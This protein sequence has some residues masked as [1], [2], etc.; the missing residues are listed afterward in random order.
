MSRSAGT[1]RCCGSAGIPRR[2][3]ACHAQ[4]CGW[5]VA[6][7]KMNPASESR[8]LTGRDGQAAFECGSIKVS[9]MSLTIRRKRGQSVR[10]G[11]AVLT[12]EASGFGGARLRID[13][14]DHVRIVR[15]DGPE[16]GASASSADPSAGP[17]VGMTLRRCRRSH[18][19][20]LEALRRMFEVPPLQA[21]EYR[22]DALARWVQ[23]RRS[24]RGRN[25][26]PAFGC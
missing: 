20:R 1:V 13:A 7:P 5:R 18:R 24:R 8:T 4:G 10:I 14:P 11:E 16:D 2:P 26:G 21:V 25:A 23:D 22:T 12:V 17:A 9:I 15:L 6:S 19:V 3:A